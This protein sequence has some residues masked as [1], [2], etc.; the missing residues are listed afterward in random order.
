MTADKE[1]EQSCTPCSRRI[2]SKRRPIRDRRHPSHSSVE[3]K[4]ASR[5]P[6]GWRH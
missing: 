5:V 1:T 3:S 6:A 2:D 4:A